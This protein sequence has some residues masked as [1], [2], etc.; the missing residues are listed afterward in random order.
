MFLHMWP[1]FMVHIIFLL[2]RAGLDF[3]KY[4]LLSI[5]Y[6]STYLLLKSKLRHT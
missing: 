1:K 2:A 6:P 5:I 4:L 3:S